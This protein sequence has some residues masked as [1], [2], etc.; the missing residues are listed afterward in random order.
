LLRKGIV[1]DRDAFAIAL[2]PRR[3]PFDH[4]DTQPPRILQAGYT[5]GVPYL[6][7]DRET[8]Q[9]VRPGYHFRS[10]IVKAPKKDAAQGEPSPEVATGVFQQQEYAGLSG[11]D[12]ANRP[13][14]MGGDFQHAPNPNGRN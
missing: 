9:P 2:N 13:G 6:V 10:H 3:I 11:L 1:S 5:V 12:A 7:I 8:M 14:E 4:A